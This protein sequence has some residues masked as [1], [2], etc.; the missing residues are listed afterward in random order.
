MND[1]SAGHTQAPAWV[2][3]SRIVADVHALAR[4]RSTPPRFC[5]HIDAPLNGVHRITRRQVGRD[6]CIAVLRFCGTTMMLQALG[7]PPRCPTQVRRSF[8]A[9]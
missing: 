4:A 5:N 9:L 1:T 6:P 8:E 3:T 2:S 7:G